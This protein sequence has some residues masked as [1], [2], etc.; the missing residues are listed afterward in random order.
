MDFWIVRLLFSQVDSVGVE[1]PYK[2][3]VV[4]WLWPWK[5][6]GPPDDKWAKAPFISLSF[7]GTGDFGDAK[8]W[9]LKELDELWDNF[10]KRMNEHTMQSENS[11]PDQFA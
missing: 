10:A 9:T 11:D 6:T 8:F 7:T 3:D 5:R 4:I 1:F 2:G